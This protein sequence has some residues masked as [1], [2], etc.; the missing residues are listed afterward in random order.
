MSTNSATWPLSYCTLDR[1]PLFKLPETL[2]EQI[3]LA[4]RAGFDFVTPDMFALRAYVAEHGSVAPLREHLDRVGLGVCDIA[5]AN[6]SD[7]RD[8]S[9][10]ETRELAGF[11]ATLGASWIQSRITG[12]LEDPRVLDTYRMC[13][14]LADDRDLGFGLEFSPFTPINSLASAREILEK[15]RGAAPRQA[16]VVDSWHLSHSDPVEALADLPATDIAFVQLS[17]VIDGAGVTTAATM[18]HR[19]L[20]G[21]GV[22]PLD[23]YVAALE[24][25]GFD[26]IVS[27]EVLNAELRALPAAD[28]IERTFAST[29]KVLGRA[30][31]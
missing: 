16:I 7:D 9:L 8:A 24:R 30:D 26:G 4:A 11:G 10:A 19:A 14:G 5:G 28:Y 27:V 20:P 22:L 3:D 1:S 13:A 29:A 25:T 21:E 23:R 17:D 31:A 12:P 15:V 18:H 2:H 6:I